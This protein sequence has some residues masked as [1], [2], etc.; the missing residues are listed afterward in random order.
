MIRAILLAAAAVT[1]TSAAAP[2]AAQTMPLDQFIERGTKLERKGPLAMLHRS[3]IK[4]LMGEGRAAG[5]LNRAERIADEKAGRKAAYCPPANAKA[6][7]IN[8]RQLLGELRAIPA[9]KRRG[10]TVRDGMRHLSAQ[11]YPCPA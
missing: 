11:R 7:N 9:A 3:E 5:E 2:V 8:P 10:M 4:L 1:L 6:Q